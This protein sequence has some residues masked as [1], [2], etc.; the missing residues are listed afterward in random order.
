MQMSVLKFKFLDLK[1][2]KYLYYTVTAGTWPNVLKNNSHSPCEGLSRLLVQFT[3]PS[4][5]PTEKHTK[6]EQ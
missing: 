4:T 3:Q 2:F 5:L 6:Q 1:I